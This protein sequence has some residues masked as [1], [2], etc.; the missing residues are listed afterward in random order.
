VRSGGI[1]RGRAGTWLPGRGL[2]RVR[3][4]A[5][6]VCLMAAGAAVVGSAS[7]LVAR[8]SL[9]RQADGQL[10]AYTAVLVSRSFGAAPAVG[11]VPGPGGPGGGRLAVEV[12]NSAGQLVMR[13]GRIP[14]VSGTVAA[15]AGRLVAVPAGHGGG[16]WIVTAEPVRYRAQRILFAYGSDDVSL[17]IDGPNRPGLAGRLIVGLDLGGVDRAVGRFVLA[18]LAVSGVAALGVAAVGA[19]G[20][21]AALRPL[22][23]MAKTMAAVSAGELS[24]RVPDRGARDEVSRLTRSLNTMLGQLERRFSASA[25]SEAA[26]RMS[27]RRLGRHSIDTGGKLPE[28]IS[29]IRGFAG[30]YRQRGRPSTGECDR[31]MGRVAGEA[32][33]LDALIDD[34]LPAGHERPHPPQE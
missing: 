31:M 28:P 1:R 32:T 16:S 3:L 26:A 4:A 6:A 8:S 22:A 2:L 29:V 9:M 25:E 13:T 23:T 33:R 24:N 5:A 7:V 15:G 12:L 11:V 14:V 17:L 27:T 19:M 10:R 34:L 20:V 21:R 30:A 18:C